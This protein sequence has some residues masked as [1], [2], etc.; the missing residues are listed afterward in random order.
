VDRRFSGGGSVISADVE[1]KIRQ[2]ME[3]EAQ[4]K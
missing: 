4:K 2:Y 3:E 1:E